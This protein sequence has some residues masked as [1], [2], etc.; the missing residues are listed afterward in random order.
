MGGGTGHV[1]AAA[2]EFDEE[3]GVDAPQ[4]QGVDGE[5]VALDDAGCLPT[6]ELAPAQTRRGAGSMPWRRSSFRTVLGRA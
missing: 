4:P 5:E 2:L 6:Q 3:E 1:D